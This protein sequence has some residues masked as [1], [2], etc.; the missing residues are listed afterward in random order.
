MLYDKRARIFRTPLGM[1]MFRFEGMQDTSRLPK[2]VAGTEL[3]PSIGSY[4][5][6]EIIIDK[7]PKVVYY[8]HAMLA[9]VLKFVPN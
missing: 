6:E 3:D 8:N 1:T 5:L 9:L 7:D 4:A 2:A